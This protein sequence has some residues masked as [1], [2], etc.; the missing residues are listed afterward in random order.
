M[1]PDVAR[2][3]VDHHHDLAR[4]E[5]RAVGRVPVHHLVDHLQLDEVVA[6]ARRAQARVAE[7]LVARAG[8]GRRCVPRLPA[9]ARQADAR[10][11][12]GLQPVAVA[13]RPEPLV[14]HGVQERGRPVVEQRA[15]RRRVHR[16]VAPV[17]EQAAREPRE[18]L[19]LVRRHLVQREAGGQQAHAAVDVGADRGGNHE[20]AIGGDDAAHRRDRA[21]MKVRRRA[22]LAH[23]VRAVGRAHAGKGQQL[24]HGFFFQRQALRQKHGRLRGFVAQVIDAV[25]VIDGDVRARKGALESRKMTVGGAAHGCNS[26]RGNRVGFRAPSHRVARRKRSTACLGARGSLF[27]AAAEIQESGRILATR[28]ACE[29]SAQARASFFP[30]SPSVNQS[31]AVNTVSTPV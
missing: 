17:V 18:Q 13:G 28:S 26:I 20:V 27:L 16:H 7:H 8:V 22:G 25:A 24:V 3:A 21:R 31:G 9:E 12:L 14:A 10:A 29:H 15:K 11:D 2:A 1:E 6:A 4:L 23:A 19:R 30:I 5:P